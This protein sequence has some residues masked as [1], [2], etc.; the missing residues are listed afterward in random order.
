MLEE[1]ERKMKLTE[2]KHG[3]TRDGEI[4]GSILSMLG[5]ILSS[6][7]LK[8][9]TFDISGISAKAQCRGSVCM[10]VCV[11]GGGGLISASALQY[12]RRRTGSLHELNHRNTYLLFVG[13]HYHPHLQRTPDAVLYNIHGLSLIH[14]SEP[15]RPP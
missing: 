6:S 11:G 15:T 8:D 9:G 13:R 1:H 2:P 3:R 14:I 10:C 7:S 4:P 5:Y 12:R